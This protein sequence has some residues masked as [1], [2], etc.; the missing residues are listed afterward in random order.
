VK[1]NHRKE[2]CA[3]GNKA[4]IIT[5]KSSSRK[6]GSLR[7]VIDALD[8]DSIPYCI[9]D[10]IEENPSVETVMEATEIG[11]REKVDFVIGVGGG[12]P[13]DAA[14][15]IALMVCNKNAAS[16]VLYKRVTLPALPVVA[17][18]TTAGTGSEATP[19]A[20][21]T[22]H[23][24]KTKSS[25][26]HKIF[27]V[28]ALVDYSYLETVPFSI[29][30]NTAIDTLGHLIESYMNVNATLYSKMMCDYGFD[31]W[32][33]VK[34][35]LLGEIPNEEDYETLMTASTIAGMAISHTATSLPHG[36]SY[37]LTYEKDIPHGKAVG[38]F[39]GAY[40]NGDSKEKDR[41]HI[42]EKLGFE[43][44]SDLRGFIH[45]TLGEVIISIED[46]ERY[47]QGIM[48]NKGKLANCPYEVSEELMRK[49]IEESVRIK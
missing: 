43:N 14:K 23:T 5:G 20:I 25:I 32:S 13:L 35:V 34:Q 44:S 40:L 4:F 1:E 47:T 22:I 6:N 48:G 49:I 18:P 27:P 15:A 36:L 30:V 24:K 42:L 38:V 37:Y 33:S 26:S 11:R 28:L 29:L 21:L 45:K 31:L 12:S 2:L 46:F 9:F 7:A 17:I 8:L 16:E 10:Q 3:L 19:Y 41:K 39:L